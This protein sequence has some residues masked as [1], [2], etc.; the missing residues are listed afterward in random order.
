M[1]MRWFL[2]ASYLIWGL[3][4]S[5]LLLTMVLLILTYSISIIFCFGRTKAKCSRQKSFQIKFCLAKVNFSFTQ[6]AFGLVAKFL[7]STK[8]KLF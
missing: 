3:I 6:S 5:F 2:Y 8:L 4:S 1:C 7:N